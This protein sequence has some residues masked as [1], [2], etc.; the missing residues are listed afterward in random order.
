MAFTKWLSAICLVFCLT[1]C[2]SVPQFAERNQ[3]QTDSKGEPAELTRTENPY[4]KHNWKN[5]RNLDSSVEARFTSALISLEI[6]EFEFARQQF[7]ELSIEHPK[8]SGPWVNLGIIHYQMGNIEQAEQSWA[9][10]IKLNRLNFDAYTNLGL[11]KREQGQFEEAEAIYKKALK[12]WPDNAEIRCNLGIL[13]D[14]YKGE[15]VLALQEYLHCE[16]LS[17]EPSRQLR[18]WIV[19]L[20]RRTQTLV[21]N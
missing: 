14:L 21:T 5:R 16:Q 1:S 13:Y 6:G 18:G 12:K 15:Q 8:L 9:K 20:E 19:D 2:G 4:W 3:A 17:D 7:T 11:L 10:A